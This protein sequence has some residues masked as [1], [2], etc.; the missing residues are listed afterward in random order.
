MSDKAV[1]KPYISCDYDVVNHLGKYD[2]SR[3]INDIKTLVSKKNVISQ[4]C[5][6][7]M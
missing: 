6:P 7:A 1:I 4:M 2:N 3:K 5:L